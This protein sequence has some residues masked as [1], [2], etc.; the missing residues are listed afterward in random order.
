MGRLIVNAG[1]PPSKFRVYSWI[2][3]ALLWAAAAFSEPAHFPFSFS[4]VILISLGTPLLIGDAL[5]I[6]EGGIFSDAL[7][8]SWNRVKD[9]RWEHAGGGKQVQWSGKVEPGPAI[10]KVELV[11]PL[12]FRRIVQIRVPYAQVDAVEHAVSAKVPVR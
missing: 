6:R 7:I 11:K 3:Y 12:F 2:F 8:I 9:W 5:E 1:K 4:T 10:M